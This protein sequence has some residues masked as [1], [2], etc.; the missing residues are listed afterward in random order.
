MRKK[1]IIISCFFLFCFISLKS[2]V[3]INT[4]NPL[5]WFHVDGLENT[6][7]SG[8]SVTNNTDD[9]IVSKTGNVG[10]GTSNPTNKL[11]IVNTGANTGLQIPTEAANGKLLSTDSVGNTQWTLSPEHFFTYLSTT[12]GSITVSTTSAAPYTKMTAFVSTID[13][14]KTK[15]GDTYGW[16]DTN[17]QFKVPADGIYRIVINGFFNTTVSGRNP[18]IYVYLNGTM[19][20][21]CGLVSITDPGGD[22]CAYTMTIVNLSK[23]DVLDFRIGSNGTSGTGIVKYYAD[24][25]HTYAYIEAL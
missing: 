15:Y 11:T 1:I 25:G 18:R 22:V 24:A 10:I 3:G 21:L 13:E 6:T 5:G 2:Q 8:T 4:T 9:V 7:V 23:D 20:S 19:S 16:D 17:K 14:I 12:G